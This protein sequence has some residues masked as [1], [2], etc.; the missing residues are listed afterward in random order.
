[1]KKLIILSALMMNAMSV[2]PQIEKITSLFR[3]A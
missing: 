2:N 3:W 1:M